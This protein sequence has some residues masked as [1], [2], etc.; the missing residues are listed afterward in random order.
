MAKIIHLEKR[1][2]IKQRLKLLKAK[3]IMLNRL[4]KKPIEIEQNKENNKE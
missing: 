4:R 2:R 1:R 3:R